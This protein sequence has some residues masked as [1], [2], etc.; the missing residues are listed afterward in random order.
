M[1]ERI[2]MWEKLK[3]K[4]KSLTIWAAGVV[5]TCGLCANCDLVVNAAESNFV[6][7]AEMLPSGE[8]TYDIQLNVENLGTDWEGTVRVIVDESYNRPSAYDT[9][10]SLPQGS[11]K[12][13]VVKVPEDSVEETDGTVWVSLWN[14][15][16]KKVA[17]REIKRLLLEEA[18]CL[19]LGI[20]SDEY[21]SL[22]YLDMGGETFYFGGD[23]YPIRLEELKQGSLTDRLEAVDFVVI[24]TYNTD[25]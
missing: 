1:K 6:I 13:F 23:E 4:S 12:Q 21:S 17:E 19:T 18:E 16:N 15:K 3:Q 10:I 7:E 22:T 9:A 24:D 2:N 25:I 11:E 5:L 20:L 14:K 8:E